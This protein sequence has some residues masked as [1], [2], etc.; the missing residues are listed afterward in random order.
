M[1]TYTI[2]CLSLSLMGCQAPEAPSAQVAPE[3]A[4]KLETQKPV[5]KAPVHAKDKKAGAL[6]TTRK[7]AD[8]NRIPNDAIHAPYRKSAPKAGSRLPSGHPPMKGAA[9]AP[10][11]PQTPKGEEG[12]ALPLPLEGP[13]SVDELKRRLAKLSD[14]DKKKAIEN[15]FRLTFTLEREKRNPAR[16]KVLLTPLVDDP[17][18]GATASRILG[19]VAVSQGFDFNGAMQHY[20]AAVK[21]D[22][23]YGEAHYALAFMHVRGDKEAGLIHFKRAQALD[24][25]DVR[26][27]ERFYP[28]ASSP[29]TKQ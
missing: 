21:K 10:F 3:A 6:L 20:G 13:G 15:A 11:A 26:G 14:A 28:G 7:P 25:P 29:A 8:P 1:R 12:V 22:A 2:L 24:V 19:Y 16:A 4:P 18:C 5:A 23:D 27:I 17:K 9:H